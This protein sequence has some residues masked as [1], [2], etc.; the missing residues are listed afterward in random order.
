VIIKSENKPTQVGRT[1]FSNGHFHHTNMVVTH[2]LRPIIILEPESI[3]YDNDPIVQGIVEGS[4]Q[5]K[6]E[7]DNCRAVLTE[8]VSL[9]NLKDTEGKTANYEERQPKAWEAAKDFLKEYQHY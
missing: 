4:E 9:K 3:D 7:Y 2:W 8:L 6:S 1:Y 5:W